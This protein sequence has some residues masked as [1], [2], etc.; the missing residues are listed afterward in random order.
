M[1]LFL[2]SSL[3]SLQKTICCPLVL[4]LL[5]APKDWFLAAV[6]ILVIGLIYANF[7]RSPL[8]FD[9]GVL[10]DIITQGHTNF[11]SHFGLRWFPYASLELTWRLA[12]V[13]MFWLHTGNLLLHAANAVLLFIF[14]QALFNTVLADCNS[15]L[16]LSSP[17]LSTKWFAFFAALLFALHPVAVYGVAYL[18][19]RS[20][21][22]ATLFSLLTLC[23]YL[24]GLIRNKYAWFI[25]AALFY[26][27]AVFS[28]EHSIMVPGVALALTFLLRKPSLALFKQICLPFVLFAIIGAGV[29]LKSRGVLGLPYEPDALAMLA[30]LSESRG[31]LDIAYAYPLSLL[32]QATLFFK[33]LGL[34]V[35]PNPGWM[36]VDM[37]EP[38]ATSFLAWPHTLG[39]IG[40]LLYGVIGIKLLFARGK[41]GLAGFALLFP[42]ILFATELASVRIQEPF[43]LYRSYLWM[44]GLFAMLPVVLGRLPARYAGAAL[45]AVS[46]VLGPL[47][48]NRLETF[49][50]PSLLWNDAEKLVRNQDYLVGAFRIYYNRGNAYGNMGLSQQAIAD[51]SKAMVLR[52]GIPQ[53]YNNRG[54]TYLEQLKYPEAL[55][56]FDK[57]IELNPY[58]ANAYMGRAII[59]EI[60]QAHGAALANFRNGCDLGLAPACVR[61]QALHERYPE[62]SSEH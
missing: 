7:L 55:R 11:L 51:Y 27:L 43:V 26:F 42:W 8:V 17:A 40:F 6:L 47:S 61:G 22:M 58:H 25:A 53:M 50:S 38:F 36:S 33:Y 24:Q 60:F 62:R 44:G 3:R 56:D 39:A 37:R 4:R 5:I 31:T 29:I 48:W 52:P 16:S 57:T 28:K 49:S 23:C 41:K 59:Y 30:Q 20:I 54:F 13:D 35:V 10:F 45:L 18:I 34:W 46:L 14:L 15:S 12:G 21:L 32:T 9:D 2:T 1:F 19:Q